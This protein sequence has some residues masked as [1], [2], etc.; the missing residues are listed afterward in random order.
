M[1]TSRRPQPP[2]LH[3][4]ASQRWDERV[5]SDEIDPWSCWVDAK[6]LETHP[7]LTAD[8][9]RYHEDTGAVLLRNGDRIETVLDSNNLAAFGLEAAIRISFGRE[10]TK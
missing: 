10:D 6:P 1:A 2:R 3:P 7:S 4:H 9:V 8:E 5:G